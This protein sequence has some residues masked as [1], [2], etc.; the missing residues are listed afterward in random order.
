MF[1]P[2]AKKQEN[3]DSFE[4]EI[5]LPGVITL[6][7]IMRLWFLFFGILFVMMFQMIQSFHLYSARCFILLALYSLL[8][9]PARGGNRLLALEE[10]VPLHPAVTAFFN[11][12]DGFV[13]EVVI[14]CMERER[15]GEIHLKI[16]SSDGTPL[17]RCQVSA[18]LQ[19]HKN[20][21]W[22]LQFSNR[23]KPQKSISAEQSFSLYMPRESHQVEKLCT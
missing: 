9:C 3:H 18:E 21:F 5:L 1:T 7:D 13:R 14:P 11:N 15:K 17:Q 8:A 19:R 23:K 16:V 4:Y 2:L 12:P 20:F 22:S 10:G 6:F